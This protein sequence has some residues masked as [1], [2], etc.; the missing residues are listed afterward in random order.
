MTK[1]SIAIPTYECKGSGWLFM[2][3]LLNSIKKQDY[4]NYEVVVSDQS[5]DDL[6]KRI[7]ETYSNLMN[8][9]YI[10]SCNIQRNPSSN[11]N[12]AIRYCNGDIIKV[13]FGDDFFV[14]ESAL[15]KI[16]N[17]FSNNPDKEWLVNGCLHGESIHFLR[18]QMVP[19]YHDKIHH[20][21]NS[22]SSPSVL[23]MRHKEYF[24]EKMIHLLDTELYKRLYVKYGLPIIVEDPLIANRLHKNQISNNSWSLLEEEKSYCIGLYGD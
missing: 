19:Y 4:T 18:N 9:I 8:V 24:D 1:V 16:V 12:N 2:S 14:D 3:E 17:A 20:G 22:I 11:A 10:D 23:A 6:V 13:M 7:V 21:I 15:T 5:N